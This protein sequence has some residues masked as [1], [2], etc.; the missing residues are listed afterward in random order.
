MN[1]LESRIKVCLC[2][3]GSLLRLNLW[4]K[5]IK[6]GYPSRRTMNP[7]QIT[8][9][10]VSQGLHHFWNVRV[11]DL[12]YQSTTITLSKSSLNQELLNQW[13]KVCTVAWARFIASLIMKWSVLTR[14]LQSRMLFMTQVLKQGEAHQ[15]LM[16]VCIQVHPSPV[17][18]LWHSLEV[19]YS[20]DSHH[21]RHWEGL[22]ECF[23]LPERSVLF[24]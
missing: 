19:L 9:P 20:Q 12:K 2:K 14:K 7:F 16:T 11:S 22:S 10:C 6:F 3:K 23:S 18:Y 17:K 5:G 24:L 21:R 15:A 4:K 13:S 1:L 8:F